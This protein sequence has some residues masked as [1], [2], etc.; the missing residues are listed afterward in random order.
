MPVR[1]PTTI[2]YH[3]HHHNISPFLIAGITAVILTDVITKLSPPTTPPASH[4][5]LQHHRC[6]RNTGERLS[7]GC[8]TYRQTGRQTDT[9][10]DIQ[11]DRHTDK[12]TD[13]RT[14]KHTDIQT[15]KHTD[16]T[17]TDNTDK[18][19]TPNTIPLSLVINHPLGHTLLRTNTQ[20][21]TRSR[22]LS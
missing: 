9:H 21:E 16:R 11:T 19:P 10:A 3:H 2:I 8:S 20:R 22:T 14:D 6:R 1:T 17:K 18:S 5:H 12:P 13:R 4:R 15:N 7:V